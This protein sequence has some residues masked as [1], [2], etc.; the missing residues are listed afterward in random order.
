MDVLGAAR[1]VGAHLLLVLL[2]HLDRLLLQPEVDGGDD[3][4]PAARDL[5]GDGDEL[6]VG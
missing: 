4:V 6:L 5:P 1:A 2:A 3:G